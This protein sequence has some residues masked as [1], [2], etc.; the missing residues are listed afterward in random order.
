MQG[1]RNRCG[2]YPELV[3]PDARR[4]H[5]DS[6]RRRVLC[7]G[8][9]RPGGR[10]MVA[11]ML[12]QAGRPR[13]YPNHPNQKRMAPLFSLA[14]CGAEQRLEDC[15]AYRCPRRRWLRRRS[16]VRAPGGAYLHRPARPS[17]HRRASVANRSGEASRAAGVRA[18][19]APITGRRQPS[20]LDPR[21]CWMHG[22]GQARRTQSANILGRM[23][24]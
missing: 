19:P 7:R 8:P 6:Y 15:P 3:A 23:P 4:K 17:S 11:G 24:P 16:T 22:N 21:C 20:S 12:R 13:S 2:N 18:L 5:W 9:G 14:G 1:G 10:R